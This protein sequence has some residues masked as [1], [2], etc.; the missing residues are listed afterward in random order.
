MDA[1]YC[2]PLDF[3]KSVLLSSIVQV[4]LASLAL[5]LQNPLTA[6]LHFLRDFLGYAVGHAPSAMETQV[7]IEMK[8]A[9]RG[10]IGVNGAALCNLIITGMIFTF[11]KD[12][13]LD[14]AGALMTLIEMDPEVSVG[15]IANSVGMLPPENL[16]REERDKFLTQ[17]TEYVSVY[18]V[19]D[20]KGCD[21]K[22][23]PTYSISN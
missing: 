4:A 22:E 16:S 19:A 10:I 12:C 7:P 9:I 23:L 6:V 15:W 5:E 2:H 8:T 20:Y 11:P 18:D 21:G 14:G 3:T 13:D 17:I 1:L